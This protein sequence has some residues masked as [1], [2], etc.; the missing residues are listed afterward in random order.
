MSA[1]RWVFFLCLATLGVGAI[2]GGIANQLH[3]IALAPGEY[4]IKAGESFETRDEIIYRNNN[5]F[6]VRF[7]RSG[8]QTFIGPMDQ[9]VVYQSPGMTCIVTRID[10]IKDGRFI[11]DPTPLYLEGDKR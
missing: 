2:W 5:S 7:A 3:V 1:P 10:A 4:E 11:W 9:P 8:D 6:P